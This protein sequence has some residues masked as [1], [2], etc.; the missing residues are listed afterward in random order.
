MHAR[1]AQILNS[2]PSEEWS[3]S[4]LEKE[5]LRVFIYI[6]REG[7]WQG[8]RS[9]GAADRFSLVSFFAMALTHNTA[10]FIDYPS[11]SDAFVSGIGGLSWKV[12]ATG[13]INKHGYKKTVLHFPDMWGGPKI[14]VEN[15]VAK[16]GI[17]YVV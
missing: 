11:L 12:N 14:F 2:V 5:G 17:T 1:A 9:G 6:A 7:M 15:N 10:F 3:R 4:L 8:I 13:Y 16:V